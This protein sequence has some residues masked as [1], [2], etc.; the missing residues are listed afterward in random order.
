MQLFLKSMELA[1]TGYGLRTFLRA[2]PLPNPLLHRQWRR[3]RERAERY[4][5]SERC[6]YYLRYNWQGHVAAKGS[7]H[8]KVS[9]QPEQRL[10][11]RWNLRLGFATAALRQKGE[12]RMK[13]AWIASS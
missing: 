10:L 13:N 3:G 7:L 2:P 8:S 1:E 6:R 5:E 9:W 12:G 4:M 11:L